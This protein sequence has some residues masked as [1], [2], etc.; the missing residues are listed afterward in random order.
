MIK[1]DEIEID[2]S[3]YPGGIGVWG[4]MPP[5]FDSTTSCAR[6][7]VHVHA[8]ETINGRKVID[9]TFQSV[10]VRHAGTEWSIFE[11]TTVAYNICTILGIPVGAERCVKCQTVYFDS[12]E[13]TRQPTV[14]RSCTRCGATLRPF[15]GCLSNPLHLIKHSLGDTKQNRELKTPSRKFVLDRTKYPGGFQIWGSNPAVI[16]TS[17]ERIEEQGIH[18]HAFNELGERT[19]DNTF[20]EVSFRGH[21]LNPAHVRSYMA[22]LCLPWLTNKVGVINCNYCLL[23]FFDQGRRAYIPSNAPRICTNCKQANHSEILVSN[24]I[25]SILTKLNEPQK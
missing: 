3:D 9:W 24:P 20:G 2:I 7:G 11:Q 18:V 15:S 8:R 6:A 10:K 4:A 22:Q 14:E 23:P 5:I 1:Y 16:W 17:S 19:Q 12:L 13:S 21:I 25:I